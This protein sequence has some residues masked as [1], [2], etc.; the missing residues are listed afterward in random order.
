MRK[1]KLTT[2]TAVLLCSLLLAGTALANGTTVI[3]RHV[4]GSGGGH[5]QA[6]SYTLD[7]TIG[8]PVVGTAGSGPYE[9][10]SGFWCSAAVAYGIYL[11]LV[12]RGF[13]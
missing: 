2:L 1:C 6:A 9:L 13:P 5:A 3:E 12:Q 7:G 10:C 8:Q 4:I 11:P